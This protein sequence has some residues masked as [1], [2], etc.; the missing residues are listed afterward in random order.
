MGE[1]KDRY[2]FEPAYGASPWGHEACVEFE[3]EEGRRMVC[4]VAVARVAGYGRNADEI[5]KALEKQLRADMKQ[6]AEMEPAR[7]KSGFPDSPEG[8][9]AVPPDRPR[10]SVLKNMGYVQL[11]ESL[12][13]NMG[14]AQLPRPREDVPEHWR[15]I[16]S[17][18]D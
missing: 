15:K 1:H 16:V 9:T 17:K 7:F 6:R 2:Y 18:P 12:L 4:S 11:R 8:M 3:V 13:K 10:E 14:Y 5:C